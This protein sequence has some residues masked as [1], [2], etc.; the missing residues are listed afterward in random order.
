MNCKTKGIDSTNEERRKV[1]FSGEWRE[2]ERIGRDGGVK[3]RRAFCWVPRRC[4]CDPSSEKALFRAT[5]LGLFGFALDLG[6]KR[7]TANG[8][9]VYA[10]VGADAVHHG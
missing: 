3:R 9:Y 10:G 7:K 8:E 5:G 1:Q 4:G 6:T 2:Q